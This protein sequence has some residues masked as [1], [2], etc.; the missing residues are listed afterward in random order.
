MK[1]V[2]RQENSILVYSM[3]NILEQNSIDC[4]LKNEHGHTMG[5]EFG[6]NNLVELW[7][8]NDKDCEKALLLIKEHT[9]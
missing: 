9:D 4:F 3:K 2:Y 6:A 1:L 7:V 5:M 8:S